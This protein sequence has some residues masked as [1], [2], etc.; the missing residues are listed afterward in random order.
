MKKRDPVLGMQ[1]QGL[2][3]TVRT[4]PL[5]IGSPSSSAGVPLEL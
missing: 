5:G 3:P 4:L 2:C 1:E